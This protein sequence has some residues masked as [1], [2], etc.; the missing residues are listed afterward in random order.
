LAPRVL[1]AGSL[2]A[3]AYD[4]RPRSRRAVPRRRQQN[5]FPLTADRLIFLPLPVA[6]GL[7][8]GPWFATS[9]TIGIRPLSSLL[10]TKMADLL[11]SFE[12]LDPETYMRFALATARQNA[13]L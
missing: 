6:H 4:V 11:E 2:R 3:N 1:E 10:R 13:R 7:K 9:I 12:P 5:T 8:R